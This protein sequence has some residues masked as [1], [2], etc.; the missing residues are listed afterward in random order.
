MVH[1]RPQT[2]VRAVSNRKKRKLAVVYSPTPKTAAKNS[3]K[4]TGSKILLQLS[5]IAL[6]ALLLSEVSFSFRQKKID[7]QSVANEFQSAF[8]EKDKRATE[9]L[10]WLDFEVRSK[11]TGVQQGQSLLGRLEPMFEAEGLTFFVYS[12]EKLLFWSHNAVPIGESWRNLGPKGLI[13]L[14][15]GWYFYRTLL[16]GPINTAVFVSIKSNFKYQN[17]FLV[18]DFH[19]DLPVTNNIFYVSEKAEGGFSIVDADSDF[20]LLLVVRRETGL[21]QTRSLMQTLAV[22]LAI[23]SFLVFIYSSYRFFSGCFYAGNRLWALTGFA[24]VIIAIRLVTFFA[25]LPSV[26]YHGQLFSPALYATSM[27][28]PSLGDLF[29]NVLLF[30]IISYFFFSHLKGFEIKPGSHSKRIIVSFFLFLFVVLLSTMALYIMRGLVINSRLNLDVNFIFSLDVYSMVG[31]LII[32]CI[33]FSFFFLGMVLFRL[34]YHLMG[35]KRSFWSVLIVSA[36]VFLA[37]DLCFGSFNLLPWLLFGAATLVFE[38]ERSQALTRMGFTPLIIALFIFSII[39][40]FAL[41]RFNAIKDQEKRKT[42]ALKLASEQDPVAEYLFFEMEQ[43][44]YNDN[45][46]KN[47]VLKDPFNETAIYQYLQHHYFYDYWGK[48]DLQVTVCQPNE[49]ILVR[50]ANIEIVCSTY[51]DDY[52]KTFGKPTVSA[53]LIYLDNN[54][55]RNSY[56]AKIPIYGSETTAGIPLYHVYL[57]FDSKFVARGMGFPELLIDDRIDINREL[58]NYS[59]A[60]YKNGELI[61]K[62]GPYIYS[63]DLAVYGQFK[64]QFVFFDFDNYQHLVYTKDEDTQIII[65]RPQQ[66]FL[67]GIAPFSYLFL[68]F[69][70]LLIIF[71][72]LESRKE[73]IEWFKLNFKRRVQAFM[74]GLVILSVITIGGASTWFMVNIYQ[75]KNLS[76]I[77]EKSQSVLTEMEH[78][79]AGLDALDS[80]YYYFLSDLLLKLHNVFF[81]DINIF[82]PDGFLIASSRPRVFEEGLVGSEM[83]PVAFAQLRTQQKSQFIQTEKIGNLEY[84]SAYVPLRN[85]RH[86]LLA[87]INLPYFAKQ[88]E[89]R[90]E[91]SY[92]MLAFVNI[93]LLLLVFAVVMALFI[94]NY[95]TQPLQLIRDSIARLQLGKTDHKIEWTRNDEIGRLIKEYNRMIDELAISADLLARSE[96]ESAW[97]E[98]A[99]Q[100]AHEIKNPLTP[101]RL[102]VQHLEKAWKENV[103]DFDQRLARFTKTMVE[104]ID[105][106]SLIAGEFSDFAKM[107]AGKNGP[108]NLRLFIPEILDLYN[109]LDRVEVE[110]LLPEATEPLMVYSDR[111]QLLRVFNNLIRN[112]IQAYH[113]DNIA[114]IRIVCEKGESFVKCHVID[115]GCGIPEAQK[116]NIFSPYFTTKTG[117]MGLGLS[118]VKNI[119]EN[120]R[121]EIGFVSNEGIGTTFSFTLPLYNS[122]I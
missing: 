39:S 19:P 76:I 88:N 74:I 37:A 107:P 64:E 119:I 69:F 23:L 44:L 52:I 61:I 92:F 121:G 83:N 115:F 21:M 58:A 42:F 48:Y 56:I 94:S 43:A 24:S 120:N 35:S 111:N 54:T 53:N 110:L 81:T 91:I 109:D 89:L 101:M 90:N 25:G 72:L 87:Y 118:M 122:D 102:S 97:R 65:S 47:L 95:V 27:A 45:Q 28:L 112:S 80:R 49:V 13:R 2:G 104:Q 82:S 15:N 8:T 7:P 96:R 106:L 46:L 77:N 71:S 93:N 5:I 66:T 117:G 50:P 98:M 85:N 86:E 14:N 57:E 84:L 29:I 31:F 40:T 116:G 20:A 33:F 18:N 79:M 11:G 59:Y 34:V 105:N 108:I 6:L 1:K 17:R 41:Y 60:T 63:I 75:N 38:M 78:Y 10:T 16:S 68:L 4:G 22:V 99:K 113:K 9:L 67:E 36:L 62:F 26:F 30:S 55:G 3:M 73:R 103:P 114:R 100:V 51:F 70:L 12:A 32:G